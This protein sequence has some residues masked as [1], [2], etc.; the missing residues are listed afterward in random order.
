M[1]QQNILFY[2][3]SCKTCSVFINVAHR[4]NMLKYFKMV[5]IDGK[6]DVFKTK[7]LKIVPTIIIPSINKQFEGSEC[8]KWLED[9]IKN[10]NNNNINNINNMNN[11]HIPDIGIVPNSS[12]HLNNN[13][14]VPTSSNLVKRNNLSITE[15][16]IINN[17]NLRK[18]INNINT[19]N[20]NTTTNN[21]SVKPINQLFGFLQTEMSGFSDGYAYVNIDNPLPQS[22]LPPDKDLEIYTAPEG[23]KINRRKQ[24][25]MITNISTQRENDKNDYVKHIDTVKQQIIMGQEQPKW[26]NN[27]NNI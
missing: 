24:D 20:T 6:I 8:L 2:M 11:I 5:C 15:P 27:N 13:F 3:E 7:G 25:E 17:N 26:Y 10:N 18:N 1:S 19:I 23:D 4:S 22:Y 16:P 14:K 9:M 21:I 12:N